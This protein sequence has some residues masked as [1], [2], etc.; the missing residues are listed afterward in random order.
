M[1]IQPFEVN[2]MTIKGSGFS[3]NNISSLYSSLGTK[4]EQTAAV[5]SKTAAEDVEKSSNSN[6]SNID[7]IELS[8][9]QSSSSTSL[10]QARNKII[11]DLNKDSDTSFL[12][13]LKTKIASNEYN[14][15]SQELAKIMLVNDK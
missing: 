6:T 12:E 2:Y 5:Q 15:N 3:P 7:T 8:Q 13:I 4:L 1:P 9:S 10:S 11:S 14:V